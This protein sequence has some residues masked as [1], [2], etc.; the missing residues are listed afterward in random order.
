MKH[1]IMKDVMIPDQAK[2]HGYSP[3]DKGE[4]P[5]PQCKD[6]YSKGVKLV[7]YS[8]SNTYVHSVA[9]ERDMKALMVQRG[10]LTVA[11]DGEKI[12]NYDGRVVDGGMC[13][14]QRRS[15]FI[16]QIAIPCRRQT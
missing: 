7:R 15:M 11:V 16:S 6:S 2:A 13:E 1:I 5:A 14:Y 9:N 8:R 3:R 4:T 10:P 12:Q